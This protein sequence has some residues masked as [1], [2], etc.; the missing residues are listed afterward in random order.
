M[1]VHN[2]DNNP[3][4]MKNITTIDGFAADKYFIFTRFSLYIF[5]AVNVCIP[6]LGRLFAKQAEI[7]VSLTLR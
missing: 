6:G 1:K 5:M 4:G 3:F 2:S 7:P